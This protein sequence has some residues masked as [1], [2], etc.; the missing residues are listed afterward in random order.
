MLRFFLEGISCRLEFS[1]C[2][3]LEVFKLHWIAL[4]KHGL[5][6]ILLALLETLQVNHCIK[7][8]HLRSQNAGH[9]ALVHRPNV[10]FE[11]AAQLCLE[12]TLKFSVLL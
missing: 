5:P 3:S 8:G 1:K 2:H 7:F 9:Y 10:V 12:F 6:E 11:K 4:L